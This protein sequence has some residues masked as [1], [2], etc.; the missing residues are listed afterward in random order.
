MDQI[1]RKILQLLQDDAD[2]SS[3]EIADEVGLTPTPC[4]RRIQNLESNGVIR[5]RVALLDPAALNLS[6]TALV[7]IRTNDHSQRWLEQ[8]KAGIDDLPEV[9]EAYRT[10]GEI[11][12][13]LKV[14]VP[15]MAAYDAFYK[16]LI[17]T[18]DLYDVRTVFVMESMKQTTALPLDYL[19]TT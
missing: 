3:R 11:D 18:V 19:P 2:R 4:W 7:Q 16:R 14:M 1:D 8:F 6:V 12:Y 5:R 17:A 10:S 13:M 15:D 9:V